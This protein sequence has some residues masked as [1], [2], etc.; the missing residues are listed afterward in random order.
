VGIVIAVVAL[1]GFVFEYVHHKRRQAMPMAQDS[2]VN[3][4]AS[5]M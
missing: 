5:P 4:L 2:T 1:A 3:N